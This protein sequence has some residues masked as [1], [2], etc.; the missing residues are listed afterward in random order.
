MSP[1]FIKA[2]EGSGWRILTEDLQLQIIHPDLACALE[3][4]PKREHEAVFRHIQHDLI[5]L[6]VRRAEDG[7]IMHV[8][9]IQRISRPIHTHPQTGILANTVSL[10]ISG[11]TNSLATELVCLN[12]LHH[13]SKTLRIR[14]FRLDAT[15]GFPAMA[16]RKINPH[17]I[18]LRM[19]ARRKP[20]IR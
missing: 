6:P 12:H 19:T 18:I 16:H 2:L 20:P 9:K 3:E 11:E 8:V 13:R 1:S 14:I 4:D 17:L 7:P 15:A 10:D 5:L